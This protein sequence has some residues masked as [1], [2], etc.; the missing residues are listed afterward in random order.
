M[1]RLTSG[2][3][4]E[5]GLGPEPGSEPG[6]RRGGK[7]LAVAALV[8][9]SALM[10]A[11]AIG[12]SGT[13][14]RTAAVAPVSPPA[15]PLASVPP[16][17]SQSSGEPVVT[18]T[19]AVRPATLR[20]PSIA[21]DTSLELLGLASDGTLQTPENPDEAGWYTGGS[22]PGDPGPVVIAG[23]VDSVKGPAVFAH[24]KRIK[25]G[26]AITLVLSDGKRLTYRATSVVTYAKD[27]FPTEM[28]YGAR[29]DSELRLITCGG[30]FIQGEYID[31]VIVFAA[32]VR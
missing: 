6:R 23:H 18:P 13:L 4:S 5:P 20:I 28:V 22:L 14:H 12:V 32:L 31:N 9:S 24:L 21:V 1:D 29:P 10:V 2:S 16:A 7:P 25:A 19:A 8:G 15:S 26:D 17:A 11:G 30:A 3:G 27:K